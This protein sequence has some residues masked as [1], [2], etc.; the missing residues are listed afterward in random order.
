MP[1]WSDQGQLLIDLAVADLQAGHDICPT[2]VAFR[3][4]QPLFLAT[5]RPFLRGLHEDPI[6]E[7]AALA[8]GLAADRVL[9]SLSGRAW[10]LDDPIPPVLPDVG[11]LRQRVIVLHRADATTDDPIARST[12]VPVEVVDPDDASDPTAQP[13]SG[14]RVHTGPPLTDVDGEGWVPRALMTLVSAGE[15]RVDPEDLE[16]LGV[17]VRRCE[18]LGHRVAWSPTV[19]PLIERARLQAV[20]R[21][22]VA[23]DQA[24]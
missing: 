4:D 14:V 12:I 24:A 20:A 2:M 15:G 9:L 11:D 13:G 10:S 16:D 7:I 23:R 5:L 18:Q 1:D 22:D 6:I 19:M 21:A 8:M 3:G 17:Q